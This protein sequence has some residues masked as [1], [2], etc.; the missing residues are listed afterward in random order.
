MAVLGTFDVIVI[1]GGACGCTTAYFLRKEGVSV[2]LVEK[3][4]VGREA[5]W[6]SAGMIGPE[7]CS[8][9]DPWFLEATTLSKSFYDQFG[10][11]L[12]E[13]TGRRFGYGGKGHLLIA[14]TDEAV[15]DL[16]VRAD[17]AAAGSVEIHVLSGDK[18]RDR[19]PALPDDVLEAAWKPQGRFLDAREYT[20]TVSEAARIAGA[21][22]YEGFRVSGLVWSGNRVRGVRAGDDVLHADL[23]INAAGA[24]AGCI[25]PRV[26]HPI[27]PVHGQI[28]SVAG[29]PCGLR[30][31][32]SCAGE[33]AFGY[34]TPRADG[35]VIV[36]ATHDDWGYRKM[37]TPDGMSYLGQ[38]VDQV[39]PC[40][41]NRPVLET[42][43]GLRP[44]V[45]DGLASVGP[46]PRVDGGYLWATGHSSSGMMQMPATAAVLTDLVMDRPPRIPIDQLRVDRYLE[47]DESMRFD[48]EEGPEKR[49]LSI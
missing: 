5:S 7:S 17:Q 38:I 18:A 11:E 1:G 39:L 2:A 19:E 31:N 37:I 47:P 12:Y 20:E 8:V 27:Y 16:H 24:W 49:F 23:V 30:H 40:L 22:V 3:G 42:W 48:R 34:A 13:L 26:P 36:G 6:A 14:R 10:E 45:V 43:S 35:R 4:V 15:S 28:M 21:A 46:D 33:A 44:C 9:R 29:P 25:D 41:R 32:V